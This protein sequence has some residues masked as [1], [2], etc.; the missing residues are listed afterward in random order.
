[1]TRCVEVDGGYEARTMRRGDESH[2]GREKMLGRATGLP[3]SYP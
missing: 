1:M 3:E 2:E